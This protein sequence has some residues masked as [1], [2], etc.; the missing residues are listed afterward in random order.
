M[1]LDFVTEDA[2][3]QPDQALETRLFNPDLAD[4]AFPGVDLEVD[5]DNVRLDAS[6][7][8][9][10]AGVPGPAS[11]LLA[12]GLLAMSSGRRARRW[13]GSRQQ[14]APRRG[15]AAPASTRPRPASRSRQAR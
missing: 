10:A 7:A 3:A 4:P 2:P 13:R 12:A 11:V 8:P 9:V 15:P 14:A 1:T 6:A 5:F